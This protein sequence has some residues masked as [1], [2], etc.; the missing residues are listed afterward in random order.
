MNDGRRRQGVTGRIAVVLFNLGGP[1]RPEAVQPFLRNLFGDKAIIGVPQPF[2]R[3]LAEVISRRRAP[4]ARAIYARIGGG[5]PLVAETNAQAHALEA[6]LRAQGWEAGCF[7]AMRYWHPRAAAAVEAVKGFAPNRVVLLPL[8]PHYSTTTSRSS[9]D[10]WRQVAD[11]AGLTASSVGVCC[12]PTAAGFVE[13]LSDLVR[14]GIAEATAAG[15]A[16]PRVL[17][18]AHGLPNRIIAQGDPYAWQVEKTAAACVA[19]LAGF[20]LAPVDHVVCYQSRV[21]PLAWIGPSIDDELVRAAADAVPVVVVPIAFVSEHSET[22]VELDMEYR[23]RAAHLGVP[24][25]HRVPTV[26][27]HPAFIKGLAELVGSALSVTSDL[28]PASGRRLCPRTFRRCPCPDAPAALSSETT[29][30]N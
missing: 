25:Y 16:P 17:F 5:S 22:L 18:S 28:L 6:A 3:L 21:G 8:Y 14:K 2:R 23:E 1:D 26:G 15:P 27:T 11:R 4:I 13:A 19:Q 7:V 12:Y 9:L 29:I 10:E 20:G 30:S 24:G